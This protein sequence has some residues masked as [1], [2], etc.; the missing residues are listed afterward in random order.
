[1]SFE[2]RQLNH[3]RGRTEIF[4]MNNMNSQISSRVCKVSETK[5]VPE[6]FIRTVE[7]QRLERA[8]QQASEQQIMNHLT[9]FVKHFLFFRTE[10][11]S[12]RVRLI[13]SA[14]SSNARLFITHLPFAGKQS[15]LRSSGSTSDKYCAHGMYTVEYTVLNTVTQIVWLVGLM[16]SPPFINYHRSKW[17][18]STDD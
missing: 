13:I 5:F 3:R 2:S 14:G 8:L 17:L 11:C 12:L 1:M 4:R 10:R 6:S 15:I 18:A 9:W 7:L 16:L